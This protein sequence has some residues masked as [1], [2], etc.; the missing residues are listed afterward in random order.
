M[1]TLFLAAGT[2]AACLTTALTVAGPAAAAPAPTRTG[3]ASCSAA[4]RPG[5]ATCDLVRAHVGE[6]AAVGPLS[7]PSGYGPADLRS[8]Y[9]L[10]SSTRIGIR[11][12]AVVDAYDDP[13]AEADL[14]VYRK[15]YGLPACT[16]AN[17]CFRKV[18]QTGTTVYPRAD[19]G[20]A[21]EESLDVDMVSA[22]CQTCH[23]LL[24]EATSASNTD[25]LAGVTEA[26]TLGAKY[27]SLSWGGT[28]QTESSALNHPGVAITAAGGDSGFGTQFP[29]S[30]QYVTAVGGTS[31]TRTATGWTETALGGGGCTGN[32]KPAWQNTVVTNCAGRATN[33]VAA[34]ADPNTGVAVYDTYGG[35]GGWL[36]FGGTS[37]AAPI[38]AGVYALAGTPSAGSYPASFPYAHPAGLHDITL[39]STI[40]HPGWDN[41]TGMGTPNGTTAFAG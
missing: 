26:V 6:P 12:I 18:S 27:V 30:S 17:G 11:T 9:N 32:P 28:G 19:A 22:I 25:L 33:D 39:P 4:T 37:V 5:Y 3:P 24:V 7:N 10:V 15:Q 38:I 35:V 2:A 40:A 34:V 14:G 31:L 8:A 13:N 21:E 20:W 29:A 23:V 1:R 36:V 41:A 16:T